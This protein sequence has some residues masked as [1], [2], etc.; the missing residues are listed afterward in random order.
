MR[1]SIEMASSGMMYIQTFI[2][3]VSDIQKLQRGHSYTVTQTA[4]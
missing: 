1:Y 2:K 4:R 3:T